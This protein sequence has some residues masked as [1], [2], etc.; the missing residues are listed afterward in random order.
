MRIVREQGHVEGIFFVGMT[1]GLMW[2]LSGLVPIKE[3][4]D[5]E[6]Y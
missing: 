2:L 4:N 5:G 6:E 1:V 3:E